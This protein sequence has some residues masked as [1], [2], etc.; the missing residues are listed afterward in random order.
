MLAGNLI[1]SIS[2]QGGL[3]GKKYCIAAGFKL[4]LFHVLAVLVVA[5]TFDDFLFAADSISDVDCFTLQMSAPHICC[6]P[7]T[8][9]FCQIQCNN[10]LCR[11]VNP[12]TG[13]PIGD[14][15]FLESDESID[16]SL[17]KSFNM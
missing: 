12:L 16:C 3:P 9:N 2:A 11:C 7:D 14:F 13:V 15:T 8:G 17:S 10:G 1:C 4:T 5:H 6:E